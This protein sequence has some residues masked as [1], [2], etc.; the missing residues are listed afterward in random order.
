M[1]VRRSLDLA[2]SVTVVAPVGVFESLKT[3]SGLPDVGL[4]L[5]ADALP[6]EVVVEVASV[7]DVCSVVNDAICLG[8]TDGSVVECCF[9]RVVAVVGAALLPVICGKAVIEVRGTDGTTIFDIVDVA[10]FEASDVFIGTEVLT[11]CCTFKTVVTV[12]VDVLI[13]SDF[14]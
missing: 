9:I 12:T 4:S 2:G 6:V 14:V 1:V 13:T 11:A 8:I 3:F 5:A 7:A 10:C